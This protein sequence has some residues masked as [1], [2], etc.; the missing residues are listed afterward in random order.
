MDAEYWLVNT[1]GIVEGKIRVAKET[2]TAETSV[3]NRN[4]VVIQIRCFA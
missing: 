4:L 1:K 3:L 2:N